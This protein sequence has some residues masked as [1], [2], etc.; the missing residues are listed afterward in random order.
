MQP[1]MHPNTQS[2]LLAESDKQEKCYKPYIEFT[3]H[4][5]E[6][7]RIATLLQ[8]I[9]QSIN[10][11]NALIIFLLT[12]QPVYTPILLSIPTAYKQKSLHYWTGKNY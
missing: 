7:K 4:P 8:K 9:D 5:C 3:D 12:L 2:Q 6:D 1:M 11:L 10:K